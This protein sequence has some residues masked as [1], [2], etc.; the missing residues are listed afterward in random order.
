[1]TFKDAFLA[2]VNIIKDS[3]ELTNQI[4]STS[5]KDQKRVY[6]ILNVN[7]K[8]LNTYVTYI[9]D[10]VFHPEIDNHQKTQV[11]RDMRIYYTGS[12]EEEAKKVKVR[13]DLILAIGDLF[14]DK[15]SFLLD[16]NNDA[17]N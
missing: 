12:V 5:L 14:E 10:L 3:E 7:I 13:Q 16:D 9:R 15:S 17:T 8:S 6:K 11:C 1:M 4:T 2:R